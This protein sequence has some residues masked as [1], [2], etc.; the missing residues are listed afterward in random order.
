M[1]SPFCVLELFMGC[2]TQWDRPSCVG[3]LHPSSG[4]TTQPAGPCDCPGALWD[5]P[6]HTLSIPAHSYPVSMA[7]PAQLTLGVERHGAANRLSSKRPWAGSSLVSAACTCTQP[8]PA[9]AAPDLALSL[10]PVC[11]SLGPCHTW[12]SRGPASLCSRRLCRSDVS[13]EPCPGPRPVYALLC[14]QVVLV[15]SLGMLSFSHR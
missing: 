2:T 10:W 7:L 14:H 4:V 12:P 6:A 13:T 5:G 15:L 3:L 1:D 8:G 11:L 9:P